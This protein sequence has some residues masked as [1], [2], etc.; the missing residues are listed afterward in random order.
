M[1]F[2]VSCE[3]DD[4]IVV[5]DPAMIDEIDEK[6]MY[7]MEIFLDPEG[8]TEIVFDFPGEEW[9]SVYN[10]QS[11]KLLSFMDEGK[12][13]IKLVKP[14]DQEFTMEQV[15]SGDFEETVSVTSGKLYVVLASELLQCIYF[16]ELE[17]EL[18]GE[19]ELENGN[20]KIGYEDGRIQYYKA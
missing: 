3:L 14:G 15:D 18:L 2:S 9:K 10:R 11:R 20:Y 6:I 16:P 13:W 5:I 17:M 4:G 7:A 12:M 8:V 19:V 1:N